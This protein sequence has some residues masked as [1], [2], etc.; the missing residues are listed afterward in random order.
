[1]PSPRTDK[2]NEATAN[3]GSSTSVFSDVCPPTV[4]RPSVLRVSRARRVNT[5]MFGALVSNVEA[6]G[7]A[8][9]GGLQSGDVILSVQGKPIE[10]ST[11]L[12]RIVTE[13]APGNTLSMQVWRKGAQR[14]LRITVG[15]MPAERVADASRG[16]EVAPAK[17]GVVVRS[18]SPDERKSLGVEAGVVVE[19]ADGPAARA[20]RS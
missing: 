18:L 20:V 16:G 17:L 1:M 6:G 9:K 7:P 10:N 14:D 2:R 8:D 13:T 3:C 15:E 5:S 4:D 19:Q 12:P 11:D